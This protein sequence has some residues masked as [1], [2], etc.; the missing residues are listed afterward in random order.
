M[1]VAQIHAAVEVLLGEPVSKSSVNSCL[2]TSVGGD[3]A[4]FIRIAGDGM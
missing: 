1:Q 4:P 3:E 2:S